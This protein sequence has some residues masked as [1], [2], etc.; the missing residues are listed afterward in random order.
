MIGTSCSLKCLIVAFDVNSQKKRF[1]H[2]SDKSAFNSD[3]LHT[4]AFQL[5][6]VVRFKLR[7]FEFQC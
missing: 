1:D 4:I 5:I 6:S 3:Q 2:K 7:V